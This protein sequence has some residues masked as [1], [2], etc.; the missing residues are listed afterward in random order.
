MEALSPNQ[1]ISYSHPEFVLFGFPGISESRQLLVI[2][3]LS[4][5]VVILTSNS[6]IIYRI[7]VEKSLQSPMYSLISLLFAVNISC[8]TA[9]VPKVLMGLLFGL[10]QISLTWCLLQMFIIYVTVVFESNI[11]LLMA[12]D[13]YVA[14]CR[15]L[16]YHDI[17]NNRF[18]VQLSIIGLVHSSLFASPIIIVA[19]QVQFCRSNIILNFACENMV[20]LNLACGDIS[21]IQM[22]GLMVRII[23][24]VSDVSLLLLSYLSILHTAMKIVVGKARNKA[25]HT[26]STHLLVA[27]LNYLCGFLSSIAYRLHISLDVQNLSSAIY[28]LLPATVHPI[29]YGIRMKEIKDCLVKSWRS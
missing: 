14:I 5:Y 22:V 11:L 17:M 24:T 23:L 10:N 12:L 28:F 8:T 1:T 7:W 6:L 13:R 19:S 27:I 29:I 21:K 26:C 2:P 15:P 25:L 4:I 3:F 18:L 16:R 9:I 20:L